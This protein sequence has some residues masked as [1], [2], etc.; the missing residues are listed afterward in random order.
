MKKPITKSGILKQRQKLG[1]W[2]NVAKY[3]GVRPLTLL[4]KAKKLGIDTTKRKP[5]HPEIPFKPAIKKLIAKRR[6]ISLLRRKYPVDI[7][8]IK[9]AYLETVIP[10]KKRWCVFPAKVR[11]TAEFKDWVN[12]KGKIK[13]LYRQG[14]PESQMVV[15]K[16]KLET[17]E[18]NLM[19]YAIRCFDEETEYDEFAEEGKYYHGED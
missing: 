19:K 13:A 17:S 8:R 15:I 18:N 5:I 10:L 4:A 12:Q 2:R 14:I 6:K 9:Q 1:A 11:K 16:I 3:Y 7:I